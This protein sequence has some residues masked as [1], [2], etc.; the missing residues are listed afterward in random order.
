MFKIP[1]ILTV[2]ASALFLN[3]LNAVSISG[4]AL[5][6]VRGQDGNFIANDSLMLF[7][8]DT[9][10][11]GFSAVS[12][13][14]SLSE[15]SSIGGSDDFI[16]SATGIFGIDGVLAS[17]SF[18]SFNFNLAEN[19]VDGND[20]FAIY[21]FDGMTS[22]SASATAGFY[23]IG[24]VDANYLIPTNNGATFNFANPADSDSFQ[25]IASIQTLT[26]VVPEPSAYTALAGLLAFA[27]VM[28]RRRRV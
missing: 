2:A 13:G 28:I 11:D 21:V 4:T 22:S 7:V 16:L 14:D 12:L 9:S 5:A 25:Q 18:S 23:A 26:A 19:G 1:F 10:G 15:G 17:G 20:K 6:D 3:N 8:V 24:N 27:A